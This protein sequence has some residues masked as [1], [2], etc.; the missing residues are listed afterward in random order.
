MIQ[1]GFMMKIRV[2]VVV[3]SVC[4][5]AMT[6]VPPMALSASASSPLPGSVQ[7]SFTVTPD[8]WLLFNNAVALTVPLLN[9]TTVTVSGAINSSGNCEVQNPS[10]A[11]SQIQTTIESE[12]AINPSLCQE[13]FLYGQVTSQ[14]AASFGVRAV[15]P[16]Q[17]IGASPG[18][19][20]SPFAV[21]NPN[22]KSAFSK[23]QYTDPINIG[24]TSQTLNLSWT[25]NPLTSR[26]T[27]YGTSPV[28]Q[29]FEWDGW[30]NPTLSY[31]TLLNGTSSSVTTL[32][33]HSASNTDFENLLVATGYSF[34]GPVGGAIAFALCGFS[35][36]PAVFTQ[37]QYLTGTSQGIYLQGNNDTKTGGCS[38]LVHF[39]HWSGY[40]GI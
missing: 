27:S 34:G 32:G 14:V 15:T 26:I 13:R 19:G 33:Y 22:A 7:R 12:I 39:D 4:V 21:V 31:S 23:D 9:A 5:A 20:V 2:R 8:G 6:T 10:I 36:A 3:V 25:W 30:S 40:G 38:N 29:E 11:S 28:H 24:I 17:A 1:P 18:A 35:S 16:L 37:N